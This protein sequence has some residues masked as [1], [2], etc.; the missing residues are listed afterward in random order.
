MKLVSVI[1]PIYNV[2]KYL[3]RCIQS[4]RKQTYQDLEIILVDD[5]STDHCGAMCDAYAD[6][7]ARI[8]VIHKQN[9]GLGFARNSGLE[10]ATG[11]YI[12]FIDSDDWIDER[13]IRILVN[14]MEQ[15]DADMVGCAFHQD[16]ED[17]RISRVSRTNRFI[18]CDGYEQI[19][20]K[21]LCP[22]LGS[23]AVKKNTDGKEMTVCTNI[24]KKNIL[25]N[26]QIAFVSER[27]LLSEDLFFNISYMVH[28]NR[29]V[30]IPDMLYF[31]RYNPTSLSKKY[32]PNKV[33]LLIKMTD[34][35]LA[36]LQQ[37]GIQ[38]RTGYRVERAYFKRLRNC[39][40]QISASSI[41]KKEKR[42]K[43]S[44]AVHAELTQ[45]FARAFPCASVPLK[46]GIFVL[47]IRFRRYRL[48]KLY[49][50]LQHRVITWIRTK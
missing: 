33:E 9:A 29:V 35:T 36:L 1:L 3:A 13:M 48:L 37:E 50:D 22:T 12:S 20:I 32:R 30:Y 21:V 23:D 26:Y 19:V 5:G 25:D 24:Y 42:D 14:A 15:Y 38:N 34:T 45:R 49:L 40:M 4:V 28:C 10:V 41:P 11:A 31:Y 47:L 2:E 16:T 6:Q 17:T 43:Y 46:E 39:L 7:D 8:K 44:G 27:E 18:C